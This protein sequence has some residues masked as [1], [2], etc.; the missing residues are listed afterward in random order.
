MGTRLTIFVIAQAQHE[1]V[2]N[3]RIGP[4]TEPFFLHS[5]RKPEIWQRRSYYMECWFAIFS[6]QVRQYLG[7]L[8]EASR[9]WLVSD[10]DLDLGGCD[11]L[12]P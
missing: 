5:T 11:N 2:A 6:R 9:P 1:L 7:N 10:G 12:H 4:Q 8:D 3:F